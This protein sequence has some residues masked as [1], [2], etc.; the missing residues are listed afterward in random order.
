VTSPQP[1]SFRQR[2]ATVQE[3][4]ECLSGLL[5]NNLPTFATTHGC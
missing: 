4:D 1:P 3:R 5:L 2:I